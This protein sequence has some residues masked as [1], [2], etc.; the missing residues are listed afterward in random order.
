MSGRGPS[1]CWCPASQEHLQIPVSRLRIHRYKKE[2]MGEEGSRNNSWHLH[3]TGAFIQVSE[4]NK[5][6]K[7][8]SGNLGRQKQ[9]LGGG[10]L[11]KQR[12]VP[13]K[14][15]NPWNLSQPKFVMVPGE[16]PLMKRLGSLTVESTLLPQTWGSFLLC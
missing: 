7:K 13:N 16:D 14:A 4:K 15:W 12:P 10:S 2:T 1:G 9:D 5:A 8:R 11:L 3:S 6:R